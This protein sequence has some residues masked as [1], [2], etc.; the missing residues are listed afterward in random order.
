MSRRALQIAFLAL[1]LGCSGRADP[2]SAP[3]PAPAVPATPSATP[4]PVAAAP[5]APSAPAAWLEQPNVASFP[6]G[7]VLVRSDPE[8]AWDVLDE[9]A[10]TSWSRDDAQPEPT[11]EAVIELAARARI[12]GVRLT[13]DDYWEVRLPNEIVIEL[14][15]RAEGPFREIARLAMP[16]TLPETGDEPFRGDVAAAP[17]AEGRYV[18]VRLIGRR[19]GPE[20]ALG[21]FLSDVA[22]HGTFVA[23]PERDAR[24]VGSWNGGW[25]LGTFEVIEE[26]GRLRACF[27]RDGR[28]AD[29]VVDGR[30]MQLRWRTEEG[31]QGL[32][33][34]VRAPDGW[35]QGF[36]QTWDAS[37]A[38]GDPGSLHV[39]PLERAEPICA[40]VAEA[41]PPGARLEAELGEARRARLYG[42]L[43]DF[44]SATPRPESAAV[45]D[46]LAAVLARH[47]D[48][49][50]TVEGHTDAIG[51]DTSNQALS[52][53]RAAAVVEA[54]AS[55]GVDRARVTSAGLGE[56]RPVTSNDTAPGRAQ[57]RRVEIA[58][59]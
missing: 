47:P 4:A 49:Q 18:R 28:D 12:S 41:P 48:W 57:N 17:G 16:A 34:L 45:L 55:R 39:D 13:L 15:D 19:G 27:S 7:A 30:A 20:E 53:R 37:G 58:L 36:T 46:E 40:R 38:G 23:A 29:V 3:A 33:V 22:V 5:A 42:I 31:G 56:S 21:P 9:H 8:G 59:R 26:R 6:L 24:L 44:A 51:D 25:L 14:G 54:L 1:S 2:P 32:A 35:L 52:E 11:A 10:G 50:I 43:F